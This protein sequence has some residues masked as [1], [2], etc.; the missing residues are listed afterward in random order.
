MDVRRLYLG[1]KDSI[2]YLWMAME[3]YGLVRGNLAVIL[4]ESCV[5]LESIIIIIIFL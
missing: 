2:F 3:S 5:V 4:L 1:F